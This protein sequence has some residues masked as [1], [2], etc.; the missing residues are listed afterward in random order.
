MR[1]LRPSSENE[2]RS[3][4]DVGM[5]PQVALRRGGAINYVAE[6]PSDGRHGDVAGVVPSDTNRAFKMPT[7]MCQKFYAFGFFP[8]ADGRTSPLHFQRRRYGVFSVLKTR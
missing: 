6:M 7:P 1:F 2:S 5:F 8:R 4:E 3:A